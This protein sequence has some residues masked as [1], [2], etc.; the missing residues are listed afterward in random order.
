VELAAASQTLRLPSGREEADRV[1]EIVLGIRPEGI[2]LAK[3]GGADVI[4]ATVRAVELTGPE[5]LVIASLGETEFTARR[6][7]HAPI[8]AGEMH[9]FAFDMER[10]SL[11]DRETGRRL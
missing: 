11:F 2:R 9:S 1:R 4:E 8:A 5:K 7:P 10:A 3:E 6:E